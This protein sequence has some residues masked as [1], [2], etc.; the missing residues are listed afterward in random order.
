MTKT[1]S[2]LALALPTFA[3]LALLAPASAQ[4]ATLT[5]GANN[6][7][8]TTIQ[9]AVNA[10]GTG[11]VIDVQPGSYG[12]VVI[13]AGQDLTIEGHSQVS[14]DAGTAKSA[15]KVKA[16][17]HLLLSGVEVTGVFGPTKKAGIVNEGTLDLDTVSVWNNEAMYGGIFN[18]GTLTMGD[19]SVVSANASTSYFAGGL[20]NVGGLV[21]VRQSTFLGNS[22]WNGGAA[23]NLGGGEMYISTTSISA[24][25]GYLGGGIHNSVSFLY[26]QGAMSFSNNYATSLGGGWSNHNFGGEVFCAPVGY[27]ANDTGSGQDQDFYDVNGQ[28]TPM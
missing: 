26:L 1:I 13:S 9:A 21:D 8:Y 14:I 3:A 15:L 28:C 4:A 22:G 6:C 18:I 5:V 12:R 19:N 10:A 2:T 7:D 17:G 24:N 20:N 11:D 25:D 23:S 27:A 16:G